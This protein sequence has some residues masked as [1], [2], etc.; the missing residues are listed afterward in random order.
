MEGSNQIRMTLQF[1]RTYILQGSK[2]IQV[3]L[4]N[5]GTHLWTW[6]KNRECI[7]SYAINICVVFMS[8]T[9]GYSKPN[10]S[11][12]MAIR[13]ENGN[14]VGQ[15][16]DYEII[17]YVYNCDN[18]SAEDCAII[19]K[20]IVSIPTNGGF[21]DPFSEDTV[22]HCSVYRLQPNANPELIIESKT[23]KYIKTIVRS[24]RDLRSYW[25]ER[26][27]SSPKRTSGSWSQ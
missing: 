12:E 9:E 23:T 19:N 10:T 21:K 20:E 7:P 3:R 1:Y 25:P 18:L 27:R 5:H 24:S 15:K 22:K 26:G 16:K 11:V 6:D 8:G 4:S 17:E 13:D 2:T 14:V